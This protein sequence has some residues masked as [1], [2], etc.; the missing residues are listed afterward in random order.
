M[1]AA[2]RACNNIA[3]RSASRCTAFLVL[4]H[5]PLSFLFRFPF[6]FLFPSQHKVESI[7]PQ[8]DIIIAKDIRIEWPRE[9]ICMLKPPYT[10]IAPVTSRIWSPK[11][12]QQNRIGLS[13]LGFVCTS[14]GMFHI[15][16]YVH[17]KLLARLVWQIPGFLLFFSF[18][19]V[20]FYFLFFSFFF[21]TSN[22]NSR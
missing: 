8:I 14:R 19:R 5:F 21:P 7:G 16:G 17:H 4:S 6:S 22:A 11:P 9:N 20:L 1:C 13:W 10:P 2:F 15:S 18:P 3:R 12:T